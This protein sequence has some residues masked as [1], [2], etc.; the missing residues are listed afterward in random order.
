MLLPKF[1]LRTTKGML[2]SLTAPGPAPCIS[3]PCH[4]HP[5]LSPLSLETDFHM[6]PVPER[7]SIS[8]QPLLS[9]S[10]VFS[11]SHVDGSWM[12]PAI[13]GKLANK[14]GK[15]SALHLMVL[16]QCHHHNHRHPH[17]HHHHHYDITTIITISS[18][19]S[20][21]SPSSSSP[22]PPPSSSS[23]SSSYH[24]YHYNIIIIIIIIIIVVVVVVISSSTTISI[25]RTTI[26]MSLSSRTGFTCYPP[27]LGPGLLVLELL[28]VQD[29]YSGAPSVALGHKGS[30]QC[31]QTGPMVS[32]RA[33]RLCGGR[34]QV[35]ISR[36]L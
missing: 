11:I 36:P 30:W 9:F 35:R 16:D 6:K 8:S 18:S 33:L 1:P 32:T 17:N 12:S 15:T 20:S 34:C 7:N 4:H 29:E 14:A 24:H 27:L 19:S 3:S 25:S 13:R 21:S 23:S 5:Q 28:D 2:M 10:R 22:P 31:D 26:G